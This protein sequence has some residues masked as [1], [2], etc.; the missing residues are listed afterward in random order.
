MMLTMLLNMPTMPLERF[1]KALT[2]ISEGKAK[3]SDL[4]QFEL[5]EVQKAA[6]QLL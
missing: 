1:E 4:N 3:V 6:L 2:A 5:T